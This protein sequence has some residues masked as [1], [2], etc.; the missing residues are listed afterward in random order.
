M[1]VEVARNRPPFESF[2]SATCRGALALGTACGSC[3]K[4]AW[5]Q[6]QIKLSGRLDGAYYTIG[7]TREGNH[8]TTIYFPT[9]EMLLKELPVVDKTVMVLTVGQVNSELSKEERRL[10][11]QMLDRLMGLNPR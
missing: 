4:C 9:F 10:A 6:E 11:N 7:Y 1:N 3:E 2:K 8:R 5:E